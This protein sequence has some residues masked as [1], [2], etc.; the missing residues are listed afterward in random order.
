MMLI[1]SLVSL[2]LRTPSLPGA[3]VSCPVGFISLAFKKGDRLD[4]GIGVRS[5]FLMLITSWLLGFLLGVFLRSSILLS[6]MTR[7]VGFQGDTL[8]K[9]LLFYV[10]LSTMPL[11]LG[12]LLPS[13]PLIKKRP[14]IDWIRDF[15]VL[16][17]WLWASVCPSL[18]G[19]T[20]SILVYLVLCLSMVIYLLFSHCL[21]GYTKA[22]LCPYSCM[23]LCPRCWP[24]TLGPIHVSKA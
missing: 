22:A 3:N 4:P 9:M 13:F 12:S 2:R 24:S 5:P 11:F 6:Q 20:F 14:S 17:Y 19:W 7:R 8:V 10:M 23:F 1:G 18:N 16:P 21:E 15:W